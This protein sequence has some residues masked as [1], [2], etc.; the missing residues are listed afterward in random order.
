MESHARKPEKELV[1]QK[2]DP[3]ISDHFSDFL[4][5]EIGAE[6]MRMSNAT[7]YPGILNCA[8]FLP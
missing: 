7:F 2:D 6:T 3:H 8:C 4:S 5:G 1:P